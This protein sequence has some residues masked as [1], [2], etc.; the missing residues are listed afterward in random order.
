MCALPGIGPWTAGYVT[1]R[2]LA[3]PDAFLPTDLGIKRAAELNGLPTEPVALTE[4]SKAWRPWRA[5]ALMHLW[6]SEAS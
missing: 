5:Y 2:A 4:R 6:H 3:D 1:M